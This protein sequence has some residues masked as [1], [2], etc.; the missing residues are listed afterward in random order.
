M[1]GYVLLIEDN[2]ADI[3]LTKR[4]FKK[5]N[6]TNRIVV[7][8]DGKKALDFLFGKGAYKERNIDDLPV[9]ILLDLRLPKIDGIEVLKAIR[10]D[11]KLKNIPV[12]IFTISK[13]DEDFINSYSLGANL[14][15]QK[16]PDPKDF[17]EIIK[18][19]GFYGLFWDG[20]SPKDVK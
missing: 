11:C 2:P 12:V 18:N 16:P 8:R 6:I 7:L 14:Y 19:L 13:K 10:S 20:F 9:F 5:N 3:A 4:A 15:V 1:K 17:A